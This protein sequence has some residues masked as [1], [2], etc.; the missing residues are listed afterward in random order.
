M[1]LNRRKWLLSKVSR[2]YTFWKRR[3]KVFNLPHDLAWSRGQRV[4]WHHGWALLIISHCLVKFGCNKL[5][6]I[7]DSWPTWLRGQRVVWHRGWVPLIKSHYSEKSCGHRPCRIGYILF[8]IGHAV[9]VSM[10]SM[11]Y[12][13][14]WVDVSHPK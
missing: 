2:S 5:C 9:H 3:Y 8:L 11:D 12:M 14:L 13:A 1:I 6:E 7:R 10:W 4:M